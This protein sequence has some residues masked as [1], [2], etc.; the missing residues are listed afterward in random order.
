MSMSFHHAFELVV[1]LEGGYVNDP[2]DPGGETKYGISERAFPSEDIKNLTLDRAKEL[3]HRHYWEKAQC[4]LY[5]PPLDVYMFDCA[6]NQGPDAAIKLLQR[7]LGVKADGVIGP[8]TK[9]KLAQSPTREVAALFMADRA[10]RYVNTVNFDKYGR[11]W[12]KR[13]F[14]LVGAA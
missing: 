8:V 7:V 9:R 4:S 10:L 5:P 3:Y 14:H 13:L 12:F 2:D 6:V 1:G 11:G